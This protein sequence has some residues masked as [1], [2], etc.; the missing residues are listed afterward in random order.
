MSGYYM[1]YVTLAVDTRSCN[2]CSKWVWP[3]ACVP[4]ATAG[5]GAENF[6]LA[7]RS[8]VLTHVSDRK[9]AVCLILAFWSS[10]GC[11]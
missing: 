1:C 11:R 8:G 5:G 7:A 4:Q 10:L 2:H 6:Q 9:P 3:Q